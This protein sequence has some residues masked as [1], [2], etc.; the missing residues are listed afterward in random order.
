MISAFSEPFT[1]VLVEDDEGHAS[2]INRNLQ[3][4]G[5]LNPIVRLRDGGE[6]IA[7]FFGTPARTEPLE[8]TIIVLDLNL[9]DIDGFEVLQR[10]KTDDR[11]HHIPVVVLTTTDNPKD[12][13]RCYALGCN[14]FMTKPVGYDDFS[15]AIRKL[16][17]M[18]TTVR[19]PHT[20]A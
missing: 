7:Y 18:L 11:T 3:R 1:V 17:L 8:K 9:P 2:L 6:A 20:R 10:L 14:A 15:D 16:G 4:A 19:V 5:V 12:I 13:D